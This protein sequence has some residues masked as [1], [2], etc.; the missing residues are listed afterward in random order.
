MW[1]HGN[2]SHLNIN[3]EIRCLQFPP[4]LHFEDIPDLLDHPDGVNNKKCMLPVHCPGPEDSKKASYVRLG[5]QKPHQ[6]TQF[7]QKLHFE[8][9]CGLQ[10]PPDGVTKNIFVFIVT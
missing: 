8:D 2:Y 10:D 7:P 1:Q 9:L 4:K 5:W 6:D 3:W